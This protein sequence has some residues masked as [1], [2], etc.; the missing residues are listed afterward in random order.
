MLK[1]KQFISYLGEQIKFHD[2][3]KL[4]EP[5]FNAYR[6]Q[7]Y[8]ASFEKVE[9]NKTA[10]ERA[11]L[12]HKMMNSHH[13][14]NWAGEFVPHGDWTEAQC[15]HMLADWM[16]M[17]HSKGVSAWEYYERIKDTI[18]LPDWAIELLYQAFERLE[19]VR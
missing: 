19:R 11:V 15:W 1:D 14:E 2:M 16:A 9:F 6:Q 4:Y 10:F 3:S 7:F 5:E 17:G 13:W 8:P 12:E 18:Q